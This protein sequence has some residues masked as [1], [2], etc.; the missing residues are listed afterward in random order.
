[1]NHNY[2]DDA[3]QQMKIDQ[4]DESAEDDIEIF[5]PR[6]RSRRVYIIGAIVLILLVV[7]GGF[8]AVRTFGN[9]LASAPVP[10][11]TL[12][13][14]ENLYYI[15]ISP[16][17]G[18]VAID[19][20]TFVHLPTL[21]GEPLALSDSEHTITWDAAPFP[22]QQC[23]VIVSLQ[24]VTGA[25]SIAGLTAVRSGQYES[26]QAS[27]ISFAASPA[28]L[29]A[30][31]RASLGLAAQRL[32]STLQ[33]TETVQPG[34]QFVN[35]HVPHFID[36]AAQ[37]LKATLSF[38]L[39][40]NPASSRPCIGAVLGDGQPCTIDGVNCLQLCNEP[41]AAYTP[42]AYTPEIP[43]KTWTIY[44]VMDASWTY[45]TS[46]GQVVAANQPDI[47]DTTG[48]EY[49]TPLYVT[50]TG[51]HWHVVATPSESDPS[52]SYTVVNGP[53]CIPAQAM[54]QLNASLNLTTVDGQVQ[55]FS[56]QGYTSGTTAAAGCLA[57]AVQVSDST[58]APTTTHASTAYCL[59]RFGVLLAA[60]SL[61]HHYWPSLPV[62]NS[63]EQQTTQS[64]AQQN[65]LVIK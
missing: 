59:Y 20:H 40:T 43:T 23:T 5:A 61:A 13:P 39:D 36:T 2:N 51:S 38:H 8:A 17:W 64:I 41:A 35:V 11:P 12:V 37:P 10:T 26:L 50:W 25:C 15:T 18:S 46:G 7:G 29:S 56:W 3:D 65:H 6:R 62:A 21:G 19:G 52:A 53:S 1:M 44:A 33:T 14:G 58:N 48:L 55:E 42:N 60:N 47:K 49:L 22:R 16:Q 27:V 28:I 57:A 63:Y 24:K 32:M 45:T 34:E 31:Q 4:E 30:T 54:I 9:P